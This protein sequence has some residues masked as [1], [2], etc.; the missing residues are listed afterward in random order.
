MAACISSDLLKQF[1]DLIPKIPSLDDFIQPVSSCTPDVANLLNSGNAFANPLTGAS[2]CIQLEI[3]SLLTALGGLSGLTGTQTTTVTSG[4][5]TLTSAVSQLTSFDTHTNGL[6]TA[7]PQN[8][9]TVLGSIRSRASLGSSLPANPC[10]LLDDMMGSILGV[11]GQLLNSLGDA[12][13]PIAAAI[14]GPIAGLV[15]AIAGAL[16]PLANA[17]AGIADQI[18]KE[19]K[20]LTDIFQ[21]VTNFS[22]A[23]AISNQ[24]NDPCLQAIFNAVGTPDLLG[25]L[26]NHLPDFNVF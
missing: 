24:A 15:A 23:N 19:I 11:G 21:E 12:I 17:I 2:D 14:L 7:L 16:A 9:G 6:I 22:F 4:I 1:T 5:S 18:L 13:A 20:A 25:C 26:S 3:G 8:M 10:K